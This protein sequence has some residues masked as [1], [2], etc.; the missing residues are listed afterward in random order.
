[1]PKNQEKSTFP[2]EFLGRSLTPKKWHWKWANLRPIE[3]WR[4]NHNV[5]YSETLD[6]NMVPVIRDVTILDSH[7]ANNEHN[8]TYLW[9]VAAWSSVRQ[10][11]LQGGVSVSRR[12]LLAPQPPEHSREERLLLLLSLIHV[13]LSSLHLPL[14]DGIL[15][16][17][18][19][20]SI[21]FGTLI[22]SLVRLRRR[23]RRI[24]VGLRMTG[25]RHF[26]QVVVRGPQWSVAQIP[27]AD[28]RHRVFA[29]TASGDRGHVGISQ[30]YPSDF[31]L[32]W[33]S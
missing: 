29:W 16:G 10:R 26:R 20:A 19:I 3:K 30:A 11:W 6:T 21:V 5:L 17:T 15:I 8:R 1:M 32:I 18:L 31:P 24:E 23:R 4:N 22:V 25:L 14:L 2:E 28:A 13:F 33:I 27:N 7:I 12:R 9:R